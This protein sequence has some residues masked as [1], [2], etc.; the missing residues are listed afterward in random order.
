[1]KPLVAAALI[2]AMLAPACGL[3]PQRDRKGDTPVARVLPAPVPRTEGA[4]F[5]SGQQM[6]LF[7]DLKARRIGDVLTIVLNETT[8]ASKTAVTKT[9]KTT[10]VAD[11]GPTLFGR[12]FTTKGVPIRNSIDERR[13]QRSTARARARRATAS[14]AA[15]R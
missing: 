3:L 12:T 5:Q 8:A 6:E 1:M 7:A 11:T 15:S 14:P 4:I 10:S 9:T 13:R 2:A